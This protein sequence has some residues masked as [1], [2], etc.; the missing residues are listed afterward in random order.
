[1]PC[2]FNKITGLYCPGCG[3]TRAVN[4]CFKFN[5]YQAFRFNA[6]LFIAPIMLGLYW[7][8]KDNGK[9]RLA[10][11]ILGLSITIALAYGL[12]RNIPRFS[13]LSPVGL[14]IN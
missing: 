12:L 8:A 3:M 7:F 14:I 4:S 10:N 9:Y 2:I 11:I 6:L 1:M 5:F 13:Y